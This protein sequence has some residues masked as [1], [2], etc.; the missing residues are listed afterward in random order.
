[1]YP[2]QKC[3]PLTHASLIFVGAHRAIFPWAVRGNKANGSEAIVNPE[4]WISSF[5]SKISSPGVMSA[6]TDLLAALMSITTERQI[7][8]KV[9]HG[10]SSAVR[11]N[12]AP[13]PPKLSAV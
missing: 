2:C 3:H 13:A 9:F 1:M 10:W 8:A 4:L 12:R 11:S 7:D 5:S 6:Q